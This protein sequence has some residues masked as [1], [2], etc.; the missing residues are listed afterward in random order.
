[1][2]R[3]AKGFPGQCLLACLL[4]TCGLLAAVPAVA[5]EPVKFVVQLTRSG[6][7]YGHRRALMQID[8]VLSDIGQDKLK[9]VVVA[10]EY[11]ITALLA[12]N[13]ETSQLLTKLAGR[14]VEFKACRISMRASGL[15]EDDFPLEV[16]FVAAGAP[17]MIRLR[18]RDYKYWRP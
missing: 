17:E 7:A 14:G 10:Y 3:S 15:S 12:K 8:K 1:M 13:T 2:N 6:E 11:G 16:D 5:E 4:M 9:F 18:M